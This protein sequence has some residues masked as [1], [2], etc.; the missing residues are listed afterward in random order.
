MW[1]LINQNVVKKPKI[2]LKKNIYTQLHLLPVEKNVVVVAGREEE[3]RTLIYRQLWAIS[4]VCRLLLDSVIFLR[5][6]SITHEQL[7]TLLQLCTVIL[8]APFPPHRTT[9]KKK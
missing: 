3:S 4:R 7:L 1:K 8:S 6:A 5:E 2:F 9:Y